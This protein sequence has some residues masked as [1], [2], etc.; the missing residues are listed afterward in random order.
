MRLS[1]RHLVAIV[2]PL[3]LIAAAPATLTAQAQITIG[4]KNFTESALLGEIM[5]QLIEAHTDI[6]VARRLNLGGT[7]IC[8]SALRQGGRQKGIDLYAEYT[9][10]AWAILLH[11]PGKI[12][13]P[14]RTYLHVKRRF[15]DE[16]SIHWLDPFGLDNTYALAMP[17]ARAAELGIR[18][19][20]D[21]RPHAE[22]LRAGFSIEFMNRTA[23]GYPGLVAAYGLAFQSVRSLEHGLAYAAVRDGSI[24]LIDA[25]ST[26]AKLLRFQLRVLVDDRE[27]FPP[28][29][30][31]PIVRAD[32]LA[33][34]PGLESVLG[35]LSFR[36]PDQRMQTLNLAAETDGF[37][38]TARAFLAEEGLLAATANGSP[39]QSGGWASRTARAL[40]RAAAVTGRL[41]LEHILLTVVA[42][43]LASLVAIPLGIL[44]TTRPHLRTISLGA[45]GVL[46]T[47]PSLALL[48]FMV[49]ILGLTVRAAI[50][51]LL[52][53]A[54]LPILRNTYTGIAEVDDDL[55]EAAHGMGMH[56]GQVLRR[57]QLPLAMRTI[58]AGIRT[59]TVIAIGVATLAAFVGA[60][61]L[62]EPILQGLYMND[63]ELVL[64]GAIPA[65]L[66]A[67]LADL[68][69]GR[70]ERAL[71]PPTGAA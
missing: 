28:Y 1:L 10:T 4:S 66:L 64:S 57:V 40:S 63:T 23:D 32:A 15:A 70:L 3:Y 41:A 43:L 37:P 9:G 55:V 47:I 18:T 30:A 38:A 8:W 7:M 21:L 16:F 71:T 54:L 59:S 20:S 26:D 61:G 17:E 62:G 36:I 35:K 34:H 5:A 33:R 13:D 25:Y 58:M 56:R 42:V 53:Y 6:E 52:L 49:P 39:A 68:G 31:A 46:Q 22:R 48:V 19:I 44:I 45:A 50:T 29:N 11:E 27:F 24:D 51:A 12:T 69:L 2:T 14:L 65:A 67:I 60:G